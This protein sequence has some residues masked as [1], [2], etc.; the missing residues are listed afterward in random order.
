LLPNAIFSGVIGLSAG[1]FIVP[2]GSTGSGATPLFRAQR[3]DLRY[4]SR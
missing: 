1:T 2:S 3:V 4:A